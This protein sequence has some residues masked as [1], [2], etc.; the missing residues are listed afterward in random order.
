MQHSFLNPLISVV[1]L[2]RNRRAEALRTVASLL[3]M[4][5]RPEIVVVD[6]GSTDGTPQLLAHAYP[7]L[8]V[9][10]S[11]ANVG[12]AAR[13]QGAA[14]VGTSYVAFSDDDTD[15]QPGSLARAVELLERYPRIGVLSARVTVGEARTPDPTCE[16]MAAS[17]LEGA[18]YPLRRLTGFMAGAAVFRTAIFRELGGYEPRLFIG[19][20]EA[21]LALDVLQAGYDIAYAPSLEVHHRPSLLR[22]SALR[23]R[24][25]ARNAAL[26]AWLR[27]PRREAIAA[28]GRALWSACKEAR[29]AEDL[30]ALLSGIGWATQRRR[31]VAPRV[32]R[33][34]EAVCKAERVHTHWRAAEAAEAADAEHADETHAQTSRSH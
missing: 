14:Q 11:E 20:E 31:P 8:R 7:G 18:D 12:A 29:T 33:M 27:L 17:P 5:E 21:L 32:L 4:P 24:L 19:G 22:D 13:N 28:T 6:N 3:R 30:R 23:R 1:V 2:T 16:R 26:V 10:R 25:L 34:R 15:W 9:L